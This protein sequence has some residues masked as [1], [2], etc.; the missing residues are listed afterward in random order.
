MDPVTK[1]GGADLLP[2]LVNDTKFNFGV[3]IR[4]C[5]NCCLHLKEIRAYYVNHPIPIARLFLCAVLLGI[6][7]HAVY[8]AH[9]YTVAAARII[10]RA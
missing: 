8:R 9:T 1:F 10:N 5:S 7:H 6:N 4:L 2:K 3:E